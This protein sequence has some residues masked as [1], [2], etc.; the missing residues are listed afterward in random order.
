MTEVSRL[1]LIISLDHVYWSCLTSP[2][3]LLDAAALQEFVL[4]LAQHPKGGLRDKPPK[5][6]ASRMPTTS[7]L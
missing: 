5:S 6:V 3:F 7:T 2:Q 4:T 1:L